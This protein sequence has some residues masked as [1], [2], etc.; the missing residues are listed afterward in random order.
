MKQNSIF[1]RL[2]RL[3]RLSWAA[4]LLLVGFSSCEE[5]ID[6]DLDKQASTALVV[7]AEVLDTEGRSY[8][9]LSRTL[10]YFDASGEH[11]VSG[12]EVKVSD[13]EGNVEIFVEDP[14]N[15]GLYIP[16]NPNFKGQVGNTYSLAIQWQDYEAQATSTLLPVT[17]I[18][19]VVVRYDEDEPFKEDGYYLYFYAKEPQQTQDWYRWRVFVNDTLLYENAGDIIVAS[20]E[21]IQ[22]EI[23]GIDLGYKFE[24]A[25][26]VRLEQYSI[27]EEVYNYYNDLITLA[28]SDGGLFSP[29]PVNPRSNVKGKNVIGVFSA[30]QMKSLT[31][32]VPE[33]EE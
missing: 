19:S 20:D 30:S 33:E 22:E 11:R 2:S 26:T 16:Q 28:F 31:V 32:I 13:T 5:V 14:Q 24:P 8:V 6:L 17:D 10:D 1:S 25:D 27:S 18:D 29:P 7:D 4:L 23:N 3:S 12:A 9:R 15:K 21:G